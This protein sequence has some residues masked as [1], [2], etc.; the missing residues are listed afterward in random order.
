MK[1]MTI[2]STNAVR[3]RTH[4]GRLV[5]LTLGMAMLAIPSVGG[6]GHSPG[7]VPFAKKPPVSPGGP[8]TPPSPGSGNNG[9]GISIV[10]VGK[11]SGYLPESLTPIGTPVAPRAAQSEW[12][13]FK[14]VMLSALAA[15]DTPAGEDLAQAKAVR[16]VIQER[17]VR[18]ASKNLPK[19]IA[20]AA[21]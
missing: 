1:C 20:V 21:K 18:V 10:G 4:P 2:H 19:H 9:G 6:A 14:D 12:D 8:T 7:V 16:A 15:V 11:Q 17:D 13:K 3:P 5:A